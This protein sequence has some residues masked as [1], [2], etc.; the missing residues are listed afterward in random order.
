MLVLFDHE[1]TGCGHTFEELVDRDHPETV[2]CPKC[3]QFHV[4]RLITG[5]RIDPSLG[6]DPA[7]PTM[8]DAWARKHEQAAKIERKRKLSHGETR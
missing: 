5:G 3:D 1:C 6:T 7:F 2:K 8:Y 4:R